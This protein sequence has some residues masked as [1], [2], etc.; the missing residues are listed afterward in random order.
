MQNTTER[1][2]Y[3]VAKTP[4]EKVVARVK[5]EPM[6]GLYDNVETS[7]GG[8]DVHRMAA[9]RDRVGKD[10]ILIRTTKRSAAEVLVNISESQCFSWLMNKENPR[11]E[12]EDRAGRPTRAWQREHWE[13]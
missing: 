2:I 11:V 1:Y 4:S 8:K 5:A 12:T 13:V 3:K 9:A 7:E 6:D 10:T